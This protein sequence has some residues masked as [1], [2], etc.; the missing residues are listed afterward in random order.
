MKSIRIFLC[1]AIIAS[2]SSTT[3]HGSQLR[4][5]QTLTSKR[6]P[7]SGNNVHVNH[8]TNVVLKR[9]LE[10]VNS[11]SVNLTTA[12]TQ[13]P[14]TTLNNR[15]TT[16]PTNKRKIDAL[17]EGEALSETDANSTTAIIPGSSPVPTKFPR[18]LP[19]NLP[20][21]MPTT[22]PTNL[23]TGT[24][25]NLPTAMMT[26]TP[27]R[28]PTVVISENPSYNPSKVPTA[29]PSNYPVQLQSNFPS[30]TPIS[31]P[32]IQSIPPSNIP[33][34]N[35]TVYSEELGT[36]SNH[37]YQS[38]T[39]SCEDLD[40]YRSPINKNLTCSDHKGTDCRKWIV[41]EAMNE[42]AI[43]DLLRSCPYSCNVPCG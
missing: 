27:T 6:R 32:S 34:N 29:M 13:N 14:T 24:P 10:E 1:F 19:S 18:N 3:Q 40:S 31:L 22:I 9:N 30:S 37:L 2:T 39:Y 28:G 42:N 15:S 11:T 26:R 41:F 35:P 5:G 4:G 17:V 36:G 7:L 33:S 16:K 43:V 8:E 25:T 23:P 12:P 21:Q 20:S 38:N